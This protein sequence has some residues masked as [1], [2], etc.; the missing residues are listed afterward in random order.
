[1]PFDFSSL[2]TN[3]QPL[4]DALLGFIQEILARLFGTASPF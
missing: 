2:F 3:F 1:M 4:I